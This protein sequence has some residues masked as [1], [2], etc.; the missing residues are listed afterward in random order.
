MLQRTNIYLEPETI[1]YYKEKARAKGTSMA[2]ELRMT[3]EKD[4]KQTKQNLFKLLLET[5]KTVKTTKTPK[6]LA[7]NHDYYLYIE[8]YEK[9]GSI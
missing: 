3:L 5:A 6:D 2:E 1:R 8:P 9:R 7:K 4:K